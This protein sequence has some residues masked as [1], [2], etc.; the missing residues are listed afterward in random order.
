MA[1]AYTQQAAITKNI[2]KFET[3]QSPKAFQSL[4]SSVDEEELGLPAL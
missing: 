4:T 2:A 1:E 3:A